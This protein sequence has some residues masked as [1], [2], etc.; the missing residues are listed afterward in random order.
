MSPQTTSL[1]NHPQFNN[2]NPSD[3]TR[4]KKPRIYIYTNTHTLKQC[5]FNYKKFNFIA[6]SIAIATTKAQKHNKNNKRLIIILT[7]IT[8]M[9]LLYI[10]LRVEK[11]EKRE[12][13]RS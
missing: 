4:T 6:I 2:Y 13:E 3:D 5:L 1:V 12:R 11:R 8:N 10:V 7:I 9:S